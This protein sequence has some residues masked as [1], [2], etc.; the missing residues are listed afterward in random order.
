M[1][2][3]EQHL[4]I[5]GINCLRIDGSVSY[6][7]RLRILDEFRDTTVSVLLMTVQTGAVG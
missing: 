3:L 1:D 2:L 6:S 7:A 4:R 5:K